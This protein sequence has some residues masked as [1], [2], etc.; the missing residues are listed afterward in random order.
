MTK[1]ERSHPNEAD[2]MVNRAKE[3]AT[4]AHAGQVD[5]ADQPYI[6]HPARVAASLSDPN[7]IAA[8]WLHDVV[9]DTSTTL[10]DLRPEF[11][12]TVVLAVDALTRWPDL[13]SD[14]YYERIKANP[15]ALEV[16]LADIA[17]NSDPQRLSALDVAT[18]DRLIAKYAKAREMLTSAAQQAPREETS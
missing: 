8:A 15:V 12:E 7:A 16:K 1:A 5:K 4:A 3:I 6:H 11:P 2:V 18:Q 13:P 14:E 10:S 9:E 17:D